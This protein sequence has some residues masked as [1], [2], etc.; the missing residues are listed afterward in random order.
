MASPGGPLS[1][2]KYIYVFPLLCCYKNTFFIICSL[3]VHE[4]LCFDMECCVVSEGSRYIEN[5]GACKI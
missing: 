4:T 5:M 3:K 2:D 1:Y